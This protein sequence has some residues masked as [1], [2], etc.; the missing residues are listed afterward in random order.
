MPAKMLQALQLNHCCGCIEL[1]KHVGPAH[2]LQLRNALV[3]SIPHNP[4]R[5]ACFPDFMADHAAHIARQV[6]L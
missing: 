4:S 3:T 5:S 1:L 6:V 2:L